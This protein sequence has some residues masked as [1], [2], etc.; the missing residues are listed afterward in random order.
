MVWFTRPRR[1]VDLDEILPDLSNLPAFDH[2]RLEGKRELPIGDRNLVAVLGVFFI[3]LAA[4]LWQI[5]S[6][7]IVRGAE[8]A[9]TALNN[10]VERVVI[11]AERGVIYDRHGELLAWNVVDPQG[12]YDFPIRA[13][14]DNPGV[15]HVLGY[16]NYPQRDRHGFF[17][18]TDYV[19]RSGVE[20]AYDEALR[21]ENGSKIVV[22]DALHGVA[23]EHVIEPP[24]AGSELSLSVDAKLSRALYDI[25]A[26]SSA[27]AGFRSGAGAI[28]D[29][30]TGEL[31]AIT[32][33]PAYDPEVM[34]SGRDAAAIAAYNADERF[35]FLNKVTSG[36]YAP[37]SVVKPLVAYAALSE[38][39]VDPYKTFVSTGE[40]IVNNPYNPDQPSRF[41]DWRAH[42]AV[43]MRRAIAFSSNVYFYII[44][45]G[46]GAMRGL[47]ITKL[48]EH[49]RRFGLGSVTGSDLGSELPGVVPDPAWKRRIFNDSW[50]LGDTYLT[51]IGQ[52]GFTATPLQILR[53]YA[54][55]G[56]GGRLLNPHVVKGAISPAI[57]IGL[58]PEHL[59]AIREGM[60]MAVTTDGGTARALE[61]AEI[62]VAAKSGTAE[63]GEGNAFVNSWAA[64]FFP[65]ESPRYAFVIM[66]DHA[67]R[68]NMLGATRVM[69]DVISWMAE[70]R[71]EYFKSVGEEK[72]VDI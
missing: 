17:H 21:G 1:P 55:L 63:V 35:P 64:G 40:L 14:I 8:F 47:G 30:K 62:A 12:E 7:Q 54:A 5:Y 71:P 66:M 59:R 45:G 49:Y 36:A 15:S 56:N 19:G 38:G 41:S 72:R 9:R 11:I 68:A 4:F 69:G 20:A 46:H 23:G 3:I 53:A 25:I 70:H 22:V 48:A 33:F 18:R 31:I 44:G 57:E 13:Y 26:T 60:R 24:R 50:R 32:S 61:H 29:V 16:V 27:Q 51:S 43:D 67:P 52:F 39:V 10:S 28:M 2:G 58:D 42:G 6:L 65:Y 37:G 34:A